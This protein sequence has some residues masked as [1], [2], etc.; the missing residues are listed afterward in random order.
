[1]RVA[2]LLLQS[3]E[4]ATSALWREGLVLRRAV[5]VYRIT[6]LVGRRAAHAWGN[7]SLVVSF[8]I[9]VDGAPALVFRR[10]R[11]VEG[12]ATLV[13]STEGLVASET[14]CEMSGHARRARTIE[15]PIQAE[16]HPFQ[17]LQCAD[18]IC[19]LVG[20]AGCYIVAPA[21]YEDLM[22]VSNIFTPTGTRRADQRHLAARCRCGAGRSLHEALAALGK[23]SNRCLD[24]NPCTKADMVLQ[25][26]HICRSQVS[27]ASI[28]AELLMDR[29]VSTSVRCHVVKQPFC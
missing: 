1:M 8:A 11:L 22:W 27:V 26:R 25:R 18:W 5:Y 13:D 21:E 12:D 6:R 28:G 17:T 3:T 24:L 7:A 2:A 19:G 16:S 15:P 10:V 4:V 20:R 23:A 14:S 29:T 9:L